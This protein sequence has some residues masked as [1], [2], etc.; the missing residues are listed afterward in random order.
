MTK[1]L[2]LGMSLSDVVRASTVRPA[3]VLHLDTEVGTL[4]RG[5]RADIALFTLLEGEFPLYDVAGQVRP[6]RTL[7]RNTLT[8]LG[9]R[10]LVR[11]APEPRAFW[12]DCTLPYGAK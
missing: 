11:K 10:E 12:T 2:H 8:I 5:A 1:F 6:S 4:R 9:G 3:Q 7:L